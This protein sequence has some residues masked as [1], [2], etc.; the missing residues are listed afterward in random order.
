MLEGEKNRPAWEVDGVMWPDS[1]YVTVSSLTYSEESTLRSLCSVLREFKDD[2]PRF[3]LGRQEVVD[4]LDSLVARSKTKVGPVL[5]RFE[6]P[7]LSE[8]GADERY[9]LHHWLTLRDEDLNFESAY[10]V[11]YV[12]R[13]VL[14]E[15]TYGFRPIR[16]WSVVRRDICPCCGHR[17]T[18]EVYDRLQKSSNPSYETPHWN[19]R[20][21]WRAMGWT[22]QQA[23]AEAETGEA[24]CDLT[25]AK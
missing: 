1:A 22:L 23:E 12:V 19:C 14:G 11:W 3:P 24:S 10:P 18:P 4:T 21:S 15:E 16:G 7:L 9:L 6:L 2:D 20:S 5:G 13:P 25:P 17:V 8:L